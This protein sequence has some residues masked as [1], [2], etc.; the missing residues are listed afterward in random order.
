[1]ASEKMNKT[2]GENLIPNLHFKTCRLKECCWWC[3]PWMGLPCALQDSQEGLLQWGGIGLQQQAGQN[4]WMKH[5]EYIP[6]TEIYRNNSNLWSSLNLEIKMFSLLRNPRDP[7]IFAHIWH[8]WQ[9]LATLLY[10]KL[11]NP[12]KIRPG[13]WLQRKIEREVDWAR[14]F[15]NLH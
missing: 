4:L 8:S 3:W 9:K 2:T 15:M 13:N 7:S 12:G 11:S 5:C 10:R 14:N 1:M 6:C